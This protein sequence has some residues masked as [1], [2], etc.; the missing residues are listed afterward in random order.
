MHYDGADII[1]HLCYVCS[2]DEHFE[3][4]SSLAVKHRRLGVTSFSSSSSPSYTS[5]SSFSLL[6]FL[7]R[8]MFYYY[9]K[10]SFGANLPI[11]GA[12]YGTKTTGDGL[13]WRWMNVDV[14][15]LV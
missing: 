15:R 6:P 9:L 10:T 13:R 1:G 4:L 7:G 5:S 12:V 14:F 2:V 11:C 3:C 8:G